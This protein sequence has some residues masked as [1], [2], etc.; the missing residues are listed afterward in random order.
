MDFLSKIVF[1]VAILLPLVI[2]LPF[3]WK[4]IFNLAV[5][6]ILSIAGGVLAY[7]IFIHGEVD[8]PVYNLPFIGT[9]RFQADLL[10][11]LFIAIISV[12]AILVTAHELI[13]TLCHITISLYLCI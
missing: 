2:F 11:A 8:Y 1:V 4:G 13:C 3:K 10:S 5:S 12:S 7:S 6:S 9:L